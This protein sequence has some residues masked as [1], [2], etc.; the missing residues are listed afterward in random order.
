M[1]NKVLVRASEVLGALESEDPEVQQALQVLGDAIQV[2]NISGS[3][4]VAVG[5]NIRQVINQFPNLD[6]EQVAQLLE[7]RSALM[8]LD[9]EK[10]RLASILVDKTK[11]FT[12]R[13]HVFEAIEEF[14]DR[15]S[16][17]GPAD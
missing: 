2:G 9:A 7:L 15:F 6:A 1:T 4:G 14:L 12:G 3:T 10:Y 8:G 5:R 17:C 11:D 16:G 13:E